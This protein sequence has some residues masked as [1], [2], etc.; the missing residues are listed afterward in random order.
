M[1]KKHYMARADIPEIG[2]NLGV[3]KEA[4]NDHSKS[5]IQEEK[6]AKVSTE[7]EVTAET[8]TEATAETET[9]ATAETE[10]INMTTEIMKGQTEEPMRT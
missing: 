9:E 6:E 10:G 1:M 2:L 5:M 4:Q 3:D 8:E 7:T